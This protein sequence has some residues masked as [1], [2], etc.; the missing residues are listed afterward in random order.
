MICTD[1][2]SLLDSYV[3]TKLNCFKSPV[4]FFFVQKIYSLALQMYLFVSQ[5][6]SFLILFSVPLM[7]LLKKLLSLGDTS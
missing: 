2:F 4:N 7:L 3:V 6:A 5:F 1:L